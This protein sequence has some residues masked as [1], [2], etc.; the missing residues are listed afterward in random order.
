MTSA[1]TDPEALLLI[2]ARRRPGGGAPVW[3]RAF[4]R[5][6]DLNLSVQHKGMEV[7]SAPMVRG[8]TRLVI[9]RQQYR[10]LA[11]RVIPDRPAPPAEDA[12]P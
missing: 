4:A 3:Y 11:D 10:L 8:D 2:E 6:T 9:P 1:G 7:F 5:F 12:N